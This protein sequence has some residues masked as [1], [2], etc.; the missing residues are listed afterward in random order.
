MVCTVAKR[1]DYLP[2]AAWMGYAVNPKGGFMARICAWCPDKAEAEAMAG[3]IPIT[4]GMCPECYQAQVRK[5]TG[6]N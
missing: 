5:L 3:R 6:E 1:P 2:P 4:H